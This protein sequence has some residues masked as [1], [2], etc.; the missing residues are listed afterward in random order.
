MPTKTTRYHYTAIRIVK[1]I[2]C[3]S[4]GKDVAEMEPSNTADGSVKWYNPFEKG[5]GSLLGS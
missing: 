1:R 2:H 5:F 3:I 4:I